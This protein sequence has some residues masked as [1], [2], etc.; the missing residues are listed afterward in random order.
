[1][2]VFV[3]HFWALQVFAPVTISI[4]G[5][6]FDISWFFTFGWLGVPIFFV[7]S[8]FLLAGPFV[9]AG[10]NADV[11]IDKQT[12][13][14]RKGTSNTQIKL[15]AYF[16]RRVMRVFPAYYA[17][18]IILVLLAYLF[19]F[20]SYPP[21]AASWVA[22]LTM[23]FFS[24]PYFL[25]GINGAWWTLPIEFGFYLILPL[26]AV[27]LKPGRGLAMLA[28]CLCIMVGY[29]YAIYSVYL[30]TDV[31]LYTRI[32]LLPGVIDSFGIGIGM[33]TAYLLHHLK[34]TNSRARTPGSSANT[35]NRLANG[36]TAA[37]LLGYGVA[38]ALIYHLWMFYWSGGWTSYSYTPFFSVVI[39]CG[40]LGA[41]MGASWADWLLGNRVMRFLGNISYSLYLWHLPVIGALKSFP[42]LQEIG[43]HRNSI[44]LVLCTGLL[45]IVSWLSW[46][47]IELQGIAWG[48]QLTHNVAH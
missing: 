29:R 11:E 23:T 37:M 12:K 3:Y 28:F 19:Q 44:L 5:W 43:A 25:A 42:Q 35:Q 9:V 38:M 6:P 45:M 21:D 46:R 22:H 27:L 47:F 10:Q 1:M 4:F 48:K 41:S 24:P 13:P 14:S 40:V 26:F 30:T 16:T 39:A 31:P 33:F 18:L 2:W 17:Q 15:K 8:G 34:V 32:S 36:L 20:G 7:L